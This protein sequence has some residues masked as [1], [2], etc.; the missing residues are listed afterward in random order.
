[1]GK[2]AVNKQVV[3]VSE[4]GRATEKTFTQQIASRSIGPERNSVSNGDNVS[5]NNQPPVTVYNW[6]VM[7]AGD[8]GLKNAIYDFINT[9][10]E[11][12]NVSPDLVHGREKKLVFNFY[13]T[14][15]KSIMP[16]E[17]G[18]FEVVF[19]YSP[20]VGTSTQSD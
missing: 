19:N 13:G 12:V 6:R 1:M 17:I 18:E 20:A 14:I 9:T 2:A 8:E 5:V 11:G 4:S 3:N 16:G 15:G 7:T 10:R